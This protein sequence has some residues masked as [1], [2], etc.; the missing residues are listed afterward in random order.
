MSMVYVLK[1]F[2]FVMKLFF[3]GIVSLAA[4]KRNLPNYPGF[5]D[6]A[7]FGMDL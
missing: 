1:V 2:S 5:V 7:V 6:G 4:W 3:S